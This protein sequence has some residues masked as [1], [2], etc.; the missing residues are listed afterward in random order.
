MIDLSPQ[1]MS[2]RTGIALALVLV[3]VGAVALWF[4]GQPAF[5]RC[6]HLALWSG[7]IWSNQNSQQIADPYTFTHVTHGLIFFLVLLPAAGWLA[8]SWR[9]VIATVIE[10]A[11]EIAE[12]TD[13]VINRY[14]EATIS[15]DYFGDSIV[16]STFDVLFCI[17]GF[18]IAS[19][20]PWR[21][22][23]GLIAVM[24][25]ALVLTIRDSLLLNILMLLYPVEAVREWQLAR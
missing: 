3:V 19:R 22:S 8:L 4:M 25:V 20:L 16:N 7:D 21:A 24:E 15:L 13:A 6:G 9:L 12:N 11:W 17:V 2:P 10:V 1:G 14:R 5:C 23:V 18:V